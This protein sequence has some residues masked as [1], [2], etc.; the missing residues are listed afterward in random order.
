MLCDVVTTDEKENIVLQ[1][2]EE[3]DEKAY[4]IGVLRSQDART[5]CF[6]HLL[7]EKETLCAVPRMPH[8]AGKK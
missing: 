5:P 2:R 6:K 8:Q 3:R 4:K 1:H 7:D